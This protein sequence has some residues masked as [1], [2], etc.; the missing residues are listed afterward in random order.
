MNTCIWFY[1]IFFE[2]ENDPNDEIPDAWHRVGIQIIWM[3]EWVN[4]QNNEQINFRNIYWVPVMCR[5][6]GNLSDVE[7]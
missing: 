4:K 6:K 2:G 5:L 1:Y 7:R 3:N